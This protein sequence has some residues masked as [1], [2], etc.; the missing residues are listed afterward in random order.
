MA[1]IEAVV[2]IDLVAV[3]DRVVVLD[4]VQQRH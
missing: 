2:D 3:L 1:M 4:P